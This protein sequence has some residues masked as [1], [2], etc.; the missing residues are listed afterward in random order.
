MTVRTKAELLAFFHDNNTGDIDATHMRDF[1]DS[2]WDIVETNTQV[3]VP[4]N[5]TAAPPATTP[6]QRVILYPVT[7]AGLPNPAWGLPAEWVDVGDT[8]IGISSAGG[9][10]NYRRIVGSTDSGLF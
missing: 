8:I 3:G 9:P 1:V 7:A 4:V 10:F 5:V 6:S 2:A